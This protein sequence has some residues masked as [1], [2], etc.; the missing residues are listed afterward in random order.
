MCLPLGTPARIAST[1][2]AT[3]ASVE[4]QDPDVTPNPSAKRN[5]RRDLPFSCKERFLTM[6]HK[7]V[8]GKDGGPPSMD[9]GS[10]SRRESESELHTIAGRTGI[11][12]AS[13]I[14]IA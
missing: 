12:A 7:Q 9:R 8:G 11:D 10:R 13:F 2:S 6:R 3:R 4:S 1:N 5:K 14:D